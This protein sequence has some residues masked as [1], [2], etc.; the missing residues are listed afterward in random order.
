MPNVVFASS[1]MRNVLVIWVFGSAEV[2]S[3]DVLRVV[4]R[5]ENSP[6]WLP[7]VHQTR[8]WWSRAI[9]GVDG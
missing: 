4:R 1:I 9:Y 5:V 7:M 6:L 2:A 3:G 8:G